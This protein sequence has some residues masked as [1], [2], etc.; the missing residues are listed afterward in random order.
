MMGKNLTRTWCASFT[1]KYKDGS[2]A[3]GG[4]SEHVWIKSDEDAD[5]DMLHFS[6]DSIDKPVGEVC[7]IVADLGGTFEW[8]GWLDAYV[9]M[10]R[11]QSIAFM[12]E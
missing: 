11:V 7:Q 1:L 12:P 6:L 10:S 4:Y 9:P 8:D 5:E 2:N 3:L